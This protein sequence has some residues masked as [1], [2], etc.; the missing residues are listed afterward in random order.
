M[1]SMEAK[2]KESSF[3]S[4]FQFDVVGKLYEAFKSLLKR[5]PNTVSVFVDITLVLVLTV[6]LALYSWHFFFRGLLRMIHDENANQPNCFTGFRS[7]TEAIKQ[8]TDGE[9]SLNTVKFDVGG[10][11]YEVSKSLLEQFPSTILAEKVQ[12]GSSSSIPIFIDRD[13]DRFAFCLDY[14]RD[15]GVV[16]LPENV[17]KPAILKDLQFLG[18]A[19]IDGTKID[20]EKAKQN[21]LSRFNHLTEETT[22]RIWTLEK[23]A[24][25]LEKEL[26]EQK[27]KH[28]MEKYAT[29][30]L[31]MK[32]KPK[33]SMTL[34]KKR[35]PKLSKLL[36]RPAK[37]LDPKLSKLSLGSRRL[38]IRGKL[39]RRNPLA[40]ASSKVSP[41]DE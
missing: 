7:V 23:K 28:E 18:F 39:S 24:E 21:C 19:D 33:S 1:G 15:I 17:P 32:S 31:L 4:N 27:K 29:K 35:N 10:R 13:P 20:D 14:M 6:A 30:K 40:L 3:N 26:L 9:R 8:R 12:K 34:S 22:R 25:A 11:L 38:N 16:H 2:D 5:F 37:T 36:L 41:Q